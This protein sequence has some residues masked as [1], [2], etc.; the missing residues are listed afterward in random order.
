MSFRFLV[1]FVEEMHCNL[2][3][4][5]N[6]TMY[7]SRGALARKKRLVLVSLSARPLVEGVRMSNV[8]E[9]L[10]KCLM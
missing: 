5:F 1:F 3:H 4:P 2:G 6:G 8:L 7:S 10:L 9:Y